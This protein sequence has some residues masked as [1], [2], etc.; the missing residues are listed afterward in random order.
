MI[1]VDVRVVYSVR[2]LP[3]SYSGLVS[4]GRTLPLGWLYIVREINLILARLQPR[5][6]FSHSRKDSDNGE[7]LHAI[8]VEHAMYAI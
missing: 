8:L 4:W 3:L 5:D 1:D 7:V 2:H 6:F